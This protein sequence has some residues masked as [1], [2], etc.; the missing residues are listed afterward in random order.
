MKYLVVILIILTGTYMW[1]SHNKLAQNETIIKKLEDSLSQKIDTLIVDREIVKDHYI[2]S[3][4]IVYKIDERYKA[5]KDS[6]CDSLV[7]ALKN[8][9]KNCDKVIVK[10]DTLIKTLLVRDTVRVKHIQY[11]QA[12]NKFSLIAGPSLSFTPQGFQPGVGICF[13]IKIK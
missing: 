2:K 4:E 11:L 10:S 8:S 3:K 7:V 13:G 1:L 5:G 6:T 9:L 12:R